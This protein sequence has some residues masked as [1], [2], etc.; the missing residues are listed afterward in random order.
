MQKY[1]LAILFFALMGCSGFD[2]DQ[3]KSNVISLAPEKAEEVNLSDFISDVDYLKL[4]SEN[5][6]YIGEIEKILVTEDRI[7]I[8]DA[9][10]S[11]GL[12]VFNRRGNTLFKIQ[13]HCCPVKI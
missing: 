13:N 10:R 2:K 4:S 9:Y 12:F 7:Y 5:N 8:L 11:S 6:F 1:L 3:A